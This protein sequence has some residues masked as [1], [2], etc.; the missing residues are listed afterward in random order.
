MPWSEILPMYITVHI[1][2]MQAS[3]L[4]LLQM[5]YFVIDLARLV[6]TC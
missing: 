5:L 6:L 4:I 1:Y 3:F 2:T